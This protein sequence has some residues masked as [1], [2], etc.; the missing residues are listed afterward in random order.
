MKSSYLLLV[1]IISFLLTI[2]VNYLIINWNYKRFHN[3]EIGIQ[4]KNDIYT[5]NRHIT[6]YLEKVKSDH[7]PYYIKKIDELRENIYIRGVKQFSIWMD[8]N[9]MMIYL[10]FLIPVVAFVIFNISLLNI[11]YSKEYT[12]RNMISTSLKKP[13]FVIPVII[14]LV[15]LI[16]NIIVSKSILD[17]LSI[18]F[19]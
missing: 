2:A 13:A 18:Y 7:D 16:I 9:S 3:S 15:L 12:T 6:D 4:Y 10:L 1:F 5:T 17:S 19:L 11:K 8:K 14:Y